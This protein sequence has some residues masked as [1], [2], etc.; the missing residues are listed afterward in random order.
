MSNSLSQYNATKGNTGQEKSLSRGWDAPPVLLHA[1]KSVSRSLR[2]L[3]AELGKKKT[4]I[5]ALS[6]LFFKCPSFH[7]SLALE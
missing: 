6:S 2:I 3:L 1:A 7:A 5:S 4:G